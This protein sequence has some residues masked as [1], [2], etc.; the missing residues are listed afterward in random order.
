MLRGHHACLLAVIN[1]SLGCVFMRDEPRLNPAALR[2]ARLRAG[3]TQHKL[4][5]L[6]GVAGGE[7]VSRWELGTSVP[8]LETLRRMAAVLEVD[9]TEL[10]DSPARSPDLRS[11]RV[12]A[13]MSLGE[14]SERSHVSKATLSRWESGRVSR[15]P[16]Q[17]VMALLAQSL[18]VAVG[19]VE[20]AF[21]RSAL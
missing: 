10:L 14:L 11:L 9:L 3:L 20:D 18:D 6:I 15:T 13:G 7:R 21:A 2:A 12:R 8:R 1:K 5:W 17:P 16:G 19:E 4:A